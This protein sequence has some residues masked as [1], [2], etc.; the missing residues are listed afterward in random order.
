M[1]LQKKGENIDINVISIMFCIPNYYHGVISEHERI[2]DHGKFGVNVCKL[3][4][5]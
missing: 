2:P 5:Y 1:R 3:I 4:K